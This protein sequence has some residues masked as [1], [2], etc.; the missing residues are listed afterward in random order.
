MDGR[1]K[2]VLGGGDG[3]RR[4]WVTDRAGPRHAGWRPPRGF[5]RR[6]PRLGHG[7]VRAET[8][9]EAGLEGGSR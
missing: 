8:A 9:E 5:L 7:G 4:L 2:G 1:A 6:R 3:Q